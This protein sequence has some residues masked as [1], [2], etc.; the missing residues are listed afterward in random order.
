MLRRHFLTRMSCRSFMACTIAEK[1]PAGAA[2]ASQCFI[3]VRSSA[4]H[5]GFMKDAP[6]VRRGAIAA[7]A[8]STENAVGGRVIGQRNLCAICCEQSQDQ[9]V[10]IIA[11]TRPP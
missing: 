3:A 6:A 8:N 7:P 2:V 10:R 9:E 1:S 4:G 5:A 11:R